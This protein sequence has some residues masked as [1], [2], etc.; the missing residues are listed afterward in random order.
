MLRKVDP[1][2]TFCNQFFQL[3]TLKFV[4]WQVEHAVV[5]R[6][7][8]FFN[9]RTTESQCTGHHLSFD[10]ARQLKMVLA[11]IFDRKGTLKFI[12]KIG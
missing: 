3:A 7:T 5:I 12:F 2:P 8:K 1:V 9:Y 6:A 4:A 11:S 10:G